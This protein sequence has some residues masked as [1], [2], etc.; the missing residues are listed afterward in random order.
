[1]KAG[2]GLAESK[3]IDKQ[4]VEGFKVP[5]SLIS[6]LSLFAFLYAFSLKV[7]KWSVNP[8]PLHRYVGRVTLWVVKRRNIL[9]QILLKFV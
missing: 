6:S 4:K 5:C 1:M 9:S 7:V 8:L 2:K 3:P